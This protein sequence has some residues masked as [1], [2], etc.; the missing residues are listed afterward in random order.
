VHFNDTRIHREA[1]GAFVAF[2]LD[3]GIL[4]VVTIPERGGKIC[5]I[6]RHASGREFLLQPPEPERWSQR[7]GY[8]DSFEDYDTSGWP[9]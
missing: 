3:N 8:G 7:P 2:A 1:A 4:R 6:W 9:A 5:S